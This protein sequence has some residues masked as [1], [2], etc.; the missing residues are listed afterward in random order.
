MV[1]EKIG[2]GK[3]RVEREQRESNNYR[4]KVVTTG[5]NRIGNRFRAFCSDEWEEGGSTFKRIEL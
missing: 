4:G 3:K 1:N 2:S 5:G